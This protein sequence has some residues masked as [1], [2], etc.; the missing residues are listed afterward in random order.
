MM[1]FI[2]FKD[3]QQGE[4]TLQTGLSALAQY[5]RNHARWIPAGFKPLSVQPV[6]SGVYRLQL[7]EIKALSFAVSPR[8]GLRQV[9]ESECAYR[10]VSTPLDDDPRDYRVKFESLLRLVPDGKAVRVFWEANFV[11]DL[12]IAGFLQMLPQTMLQAAGQTAV[13]TMT[14]PISRNLVHNLCQDYQVCSNPS[15]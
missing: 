4:V 3:S 15:G 14:A 10:L 1:Q 12:E 9:E 13:Q 11:I 6:L 7:P 5:L 8:L 2:S